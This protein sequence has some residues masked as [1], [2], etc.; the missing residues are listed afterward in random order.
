MNLT[1]G[2]DKDRG[3]E[4]IST[5][6][7]LRGNLVPWISWAPTGDSIAY[8]ARTEK[9]KT[10]IIHDIVNG[11][12]RAAGRAEGAR[13]AGIAGVQPGRPPGGVLGA[14]RRGRRHLHRRSRTRRS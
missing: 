4:Y 13:R 7:G 3:F 12:D 6:G 11:R 8:F 1:K 2:F 14:E 5:A 10:L 9:F